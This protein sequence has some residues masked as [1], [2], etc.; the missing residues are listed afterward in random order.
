MRAGLAARGVVAISLMI[1]FYALV[2]RGFAA[3]AEPGAPVALR[4]GDLE[5]APWV[6]IR[7][8]LEGEIDEAAWRA[9]C[10]ELGLERIG[11]EAAA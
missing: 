4:A 5:L 3:T 1:L 7:R 2:D 11:K 6:E 9:R 8:Y 10:A